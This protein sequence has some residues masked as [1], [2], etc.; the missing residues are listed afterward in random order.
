MVNTYLHKV[1]DLIV[2]T[3]FYSQYIKLPSSETP[4]EIRNNPKLFLYFDGCL[5]AIDGSHIDAHVPNGLTPRY[6]N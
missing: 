4:Q 3:T 1:L 5:G 2:C 6:C